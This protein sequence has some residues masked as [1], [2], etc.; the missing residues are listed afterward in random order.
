MDPQNAAPDPML[1]RMREERRA[2][3]ARLNTIFGFLIRRMERIMHTLEDILADVTSARGDIDSLATL[4]AGIKKQLDEVLAGALTP[5]Q[6][7]RV[8]AIFDKVQQNKQAVVDAIKSSD[9]VGDN[10]TDTTV[11]SSNTRSN[12]GDSVVFTAAVAKHPDAPADKNPTGSMVFT[13]DGTQVGSV[14]VGTDG[15]AQSA[16]VTNLT[17]GDHQVTAT[18]GGDSV[19]ETST[20]A[21]LTQTVVA[22]GGNANPNPNNPNP[23]DQTTRTLR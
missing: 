3:A 20:S 8:D 18:Y 14:S 22:V 9:N 10:I 12:V 19:F 7:M 23:G 13:I 2:D 11:T 15:T 1:A 4:T 17:E 16:A 5:S 6:Q 21:A